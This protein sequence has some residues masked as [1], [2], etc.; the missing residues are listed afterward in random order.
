MK[1]VAMVCASM[2]MARNALAVDDVLV[3]HGELHAAAGIELTHRGAVDFLPRRLV[4]ECSCRQDAPAGIDLFVGDQDVRPPLLEID[5]DSV[6]GP[7]DREVAAACRLG[8]GVQYGWRV[9]SA[10][11]AAVA[12]GRQC[13]DATPDERGWWLHIDDLRRARVTDRTGVADDE[14]A[15][16][17]DLELRIVDASV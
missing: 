11:L 7:Q 14:N 1:I 13:G 8:T 17:V 6:A 5:P 15:V 2:G 4:F 16:F 9:S 10:A 3:L 12:D